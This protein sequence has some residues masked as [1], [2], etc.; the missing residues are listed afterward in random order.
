MAESDKVKHSD[1]IEPKVFEPTIK[2]GK[3][4][5]KVLTQIEAGMRAVLETSKKGLVGT[6]PRGI[7]EI[8]RLNEFL[9]KIDNAEK[10]LLETSRQ[11]EALE[12]RIAL[13]Q[14]KN[15]QK[16]AEA[17]Q[18]E[19]AAQELLKRNVGELT[20]AELKLAKAILEKDRANSRDI[21]TTERLNR[22]LAVTKARMRELTNAGTK[23]TNSFGTA[24]NSF[25]FKFNFLGNLM[26]G[27]AQMGLAKIEEFL[28][29]SV[30]AFK[31]A[32]KNANSLAFA[33]KNVSGEGL[34]AFQ[35]L[36]D[37]SAQLQDNSI[38]SDDSIQQI[39]KQLIN[40][41]L[42]TDEVEKLTPAI[43][44]LA[45]ASGMELGEA[46]DVIIAGINGQTRGLKKLGI[47]F[48][49]TGD[50]TENLAIITQKLSKFQ[51]AAA[52]ALTTSAG[53]AE[54]LENQIGDLQ[55]SIGKLIADQLQGMKANLIDIINIFKNFEF[56]AEGIVDV[57]NG[58]AKAFI[59]F[60]TAGLVTFDDSTRDILQAQRE[61]ADNLGKNQADIL[62]KASKLTQD[63]RKIVA[64]GLRQEIEDLKKLANE[65]AAQMGK[66]EIELLK[67]RLN[68]L[69]QT[70][71]ELVKMGR[72]T[73]NT[74]EEDQEEHN[75]KMKEIEQK[76]QIE[77]E[78]EHTDFLLKLQ[79]ARE[80][81]REKQ[82]EEQHDKDIKRAEKEI[83]EREKLLENYQTVLDKFEDSRKGEEEKA[84]DELKLT[85]NR[86]SQLLIDA[87]KKDIITEEEY[88]KARTALEERYNDDV[89]KLGRKRLEDQLK[90]TEMLNDAIFDGLDRRNKKQQDIQDQQL[91]MIEDSIQQQQNLAERGLD[92]TLAFEEKRRA[93]SL[94]KKA[95]LEKKAR[96]QEQAQQL[97]NVFLEFLKSYAKEGSI[98]APAKA[99][100]QTL[101]AKGLSDLIAGN[102]ATGVENFKGKGTET[103]DSNL[104]GFSK[105]ESVVTAKGTRENP[106]LV[107]AMNEGNVMDYFRE[108]YLPQYHQ[109]L[110]QD[111]SRKAQVSDAIY[112]LLDKRLENLEKTIR[113]KK[114]V[115]INWD[116][117]GNMVRQE[118]EAGIRKHI[119]SKR[120]SL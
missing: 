54:H 95:E 111:R 75:K 46:T 62:K 30:G 73:N 67:T 23:S 12:K 42:T 117:H 4:L 79:K 47:E 13:Q 88:Q 35:K 91:Q 108:N 21:K 33:V 8:E 10:A 116:E 96:K 31:E 18:K 39:Q 98:G 104:I 37:Q 34:A 89:R 48:K 2:D 112:G 100:A 26:A 110:S 22:Q 45:T 16:A 32:E 11:K 43:L 51:G 29:G 90:L 1:I 69:V 57:I 20:L 87:R 64:Q 41:G 19:M 5:I 52:N 77:L 107:T 93:E 102:F 28:A 25:Q 59:E 92:N 24:L 113:H 84:L 70:H 115:S 66:K 83:E 15:R 105:G 27:F 36:I 118:V 71:N 101:I 44:D 3:E 81:A 58:M 14:E 76:S 97:A 80:E 120:R 6:T 78:R 61:L 38:F 49:D 68:F 119:T 63:Q 17:A 82:L 74:I 114:E 103:S 86:E 109:N 99:L 40:F 85:F 7:N 60:S 55:E 94:A 50:K 65:K 53:A 56:S 9:K 72:K 106:G